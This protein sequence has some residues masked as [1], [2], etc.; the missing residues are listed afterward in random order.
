MSDSLPEWVR[1]ALR[2]PDTKE[3]L[4]TSKGPA[5]TE[6]VAGDRAYPVRDGVPVMLA[7]EARVIKRRSPKE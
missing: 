1:S 3:P 5:G 2:D 4:K 6:L 7:S